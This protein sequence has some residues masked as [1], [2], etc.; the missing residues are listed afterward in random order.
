MPLN[1]AWQS[2]QWRD[3]KKEMPLTKK[4]RPLNRDR[5]HKN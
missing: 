1:R 4:S 3:H 2:R 5:I